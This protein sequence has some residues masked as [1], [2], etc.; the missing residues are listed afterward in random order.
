MAL[1]F[2]DRVLQTGT[3]NTTVSFT[4]TGS[5]VGYQ[6]FSTL[7]TGNT[8]YYAATDGTNWETGIG[9]LTSPTLLTRT[10]ILSSSNSG[11]AVTF[12]GTVTV[13]VDYPSSK[14]VNLDASGNVSPLGTVASGT[15]NGSTIGV[16]YGGTGVTSS[17][18][19][20][21][22]VLR[23][24]NVNVNANSFIPG[25]AS[26]STAAGTTTLTVGSAYYQRFTGTNTQTVVL[27]SATTM[28]L[29][30]GYIID[31]DSTGNITLQDGTPT[32]IATIVP[33]MAGY[34]FVENNGSV[35]GSW[36]GYQF[37]PGAGPSGAVTWGTAGLAMGGGTISSA[38]WQGSTIGVAYGGTGATSLTGYLIGNGTSA[39]T[40]V[41]SI[42]N[43]G[44]TNSSFTIGTTS[45]SLGATV[46]TFAGVNL[47]SPTLVTPALGTPA[48]G[49]L[50]NTTGYP[51]STLAGATLASNVI[52]SSLT[53]VGTLATLAVTAI[54]S[55]SINGQAPAGT[56]SGTT[57]ASNV[58]TSSLTSV[59]TLASL[60]VT[61]AVNSASHSVT[62]QYISTQ[63]TGTAPFV[64]ASTTPVANLSIGGNAATATT[65]SSVTGGYVSSAVAGTAIS[66]SAAT[67]AVTINNT[68]VTS[69]V[70]G[71]GISVSG[72]TGAVTFT[73]SGV[74]S[75]VAGTNVT[76]S[77]STG[78]VTINAATQSATVTASTANSTFYVVGTTSTSGGF[79][80]ATVSNTN[81]VSYNASTGA[82]SAVS[83]VSSSDERLKKN[84]VD[85]AKDF[86]SK[87]AN[88][89]HGIFERISS[90]NHE[91]GVTAQ[92]LK[93][94]LPEA[95]IEGEDGMLSVNYGAAA[96]VSAIELAKE[97]K[98]LR[99]ELAELKSKVS[100]G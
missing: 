56:L 59:G 58:V 34:I 90:G 89:K 97:V 21:S 95:V 28:A 14:S 82:L 88:V 29:G 69:A 7:T 53:S 68:G 36:S 51:A 61:G 57:L 27:P 15:W 41:A 35:A 67:G 96:L 17:S 26:T 38:T 73:N 48:S 18:G 83:H 64:V 32:T 10:T 31:N 42:P 70:A 39:F 80:T 54:I 65:A 43:A 86:V 3:A 9:T 49:V 13:W 37:V 11:S 74:T 100:G 78:A 66:V 4:L 23:D 16:S 77:G 91:V 45:V 47:S 99:A 50:T 98:L 79:T 63:A 19:A 71:T 60:N 72:S 75:I 33:G 44:L 92:S 12:S 1:Q 5:V 84:W 46:T 22:V 52:A 85:L 55:G 20:N 2:A 25:W 62:G 40:T 81:A 24:A 30:Q 93:E 94:V 8:T 6:A 87:L 76:I